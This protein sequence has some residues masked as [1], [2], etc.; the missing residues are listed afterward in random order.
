MTE[1]QR[2]A[3]EMA[4]QNEEKSKVFLETNAKKSG[5]TTT[6]SGL[7]FEVITPAEGPK[8]TTESTVTVHYTG[9]LTDGT[10]FDSSVKRGQ[11]ATFPLGG[12]IP[13]WTEG[14]QLMG[15]GGKYRFVIP[16]DLGYGPRGAGNVIPPNSVLVFEVEL[17]SFE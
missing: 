3:D 17:I 6:A 11:P 15:V 1:G 14:L 9:T 7:Q 5:V 2:R 16:P 10:E 12:V 4:Q 8:P 13:G